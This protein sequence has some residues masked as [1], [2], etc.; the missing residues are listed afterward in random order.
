M[1]HEM[2]YGR[3]PD[4]LPVL[5]NLFDDYYLVGGT[6]LSLFYLN[7]R[8]SYDVD[9]FTQNKNESFSISE[10]LK[11]F[12]SKFNLSVTQERDFF[13]EETEELIGRRYSVVDEVEEI[14]LDFVKDPENLIYPPE[15]KD[16]IN[17][18][19]IEDLYFRK[20]T[21]A[22]NVRKDAIGRMFEIGRSKGRDLLDIYAL[23]RE[24]LSLAHFLEGLEANNS[25]DL[26]DQLTRYVEHFNRTK[27]LNE[28]DDTGFRN[29]EADVSSQQITDY[30]LA[31]IKEY[32]R[33][34]VRKHL[35]D[36]EDRQ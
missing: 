25:A 1:D 34:Q 6:A 28:I 15:K 17:V 4:F 12:E 10:R 5:G 14:K 35:P 19:T 29:F 23:S 9:L 30:L 32:R 7:H 22:V 33:W 27:L 31:E 24:H 3:I 26:A 20:L 16:G 21:I 8:V 13:N 11:K 18:A 36:E 2:A